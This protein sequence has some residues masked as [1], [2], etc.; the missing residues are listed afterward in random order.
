VG[1][2]VGRY[3]NRIAGAR[4]ALDGVPVS[5]DFVTSQ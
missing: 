5:I 4:F 3:A 1:G 2:V